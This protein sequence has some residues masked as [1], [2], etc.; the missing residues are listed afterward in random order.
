MKGPVRP[1]KGPSPRDPIP[2]ISMRFSSGLKDQDAEKVWSILIK[3]E[4]VGII[5]A[6]GLVR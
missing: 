6:A 5:T 4:T 1:G 2:A 3:S